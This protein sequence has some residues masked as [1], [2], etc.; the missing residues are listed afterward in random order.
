MKRT[1]P[2]RCEATTVPGFVQQVA[3]S[4]VANGYLFY[5]AG[6]VPAGKDPRT[7]DGKILERYGIAISKWAKA[8]RK[9][10]GQ[11]NLQY[12]RF[13][14]F[15][16]ILATHGQHRFFHEEAKVIRDV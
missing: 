9:S 5:V 13:E 2:Y 7:I 11:A 8:R 14:R 12:I 10:L 1:M 15:F 16:L 6:C 3:V 4:Y